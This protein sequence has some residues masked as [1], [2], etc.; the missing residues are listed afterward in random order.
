MQL[1]DICP[2]VPCGNTCRLISTQ[3]FIAVH[4]IF[5]ESN[6]SRLGSLLHTSVSMLHRSHVLLPMAIHLGVA[7]HGAGTHPSGQRGEIAN[8]SISSPTL[9][10]SLPIRW[11]G[12][13][14]FLRDLVEAG[15]GGRVRPQRS[16]TNPM[17]CC[18]HVRERTPLGMGRSGRFFS[19]FC[20]GGG[21]VWRGIPSVNCAWVKSIPPPPPLPLARSPSSHRSIDPHPS[22]NGAPP[23]GGVR[24]RCERDK[25][26]R[27]EGKEPARVRKDGSEEEDRMRRIPQGWTH[28][29]F[30]RRSEDKLE[31]TS[32]NRRTIRKSATY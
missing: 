27:R 2:S 31:S 23:T 29:G 20:S 30:R 18:F 1:I 32:P 12:I 16:C 22:T 25:D 4:P 11:C 13:R 24:T 6:R 28:G 17:P 3:N 14:W 9:V 26:G 7:R 21:V 10:L 8:T 15:F 19:P 5:V